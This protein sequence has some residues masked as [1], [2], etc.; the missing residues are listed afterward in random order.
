MPPEEVAWFVGWLE[1]RGVTYQCNGGWAVDAL[2]GAQTRPHGDLD[3]FLDER[4]LDEAIAALR[5]RGYAIVED[6]RPVRIE[7]RADERA[8]DLHPMRIQQNGDGVQALL[9]GGVL[10]H[11]AAR[12]AVGT[13][14]GHPVVVADSARLV[15]LRQGYTARDVDRH[16]LRMLQQLRCCEPPLLHPGA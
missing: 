13:I 4:V 16:D 15:E 1:A 5:A 11:E 12:R 9:D 10:L 8:I 2:V 6:W 3:V 7:L 14:G